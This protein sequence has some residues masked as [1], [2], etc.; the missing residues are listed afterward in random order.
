MQL[1]ELVTPAYFTEENSLLFFIHL[2]ILTWLDGVSWVYWN[3]MNTPAGPVHLF[4][5]PKHRHRILDLFISPR[6]PLLKRLKWPSYFSLS[7]TTAIF[8]RMKSLLKP[9]DK[10]CSTKHKS[11]CKKKKQYLSLSLALALNRSLSLTLSYALSL[12]LSLSALVSPPLL[13]LVFF[14]FFWG[15]G[16]NGKGKK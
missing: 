3:I 13:K 16:A 2:L 8:T 12:S 9:R 14:P 4:N 6:F 10:S 5:K 7:V 11:H 1:K 15:N